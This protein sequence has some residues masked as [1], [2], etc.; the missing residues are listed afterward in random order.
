MPQVKLEANNSAE[1]SQI[2]LCTAVQQFHKHNEQVKHPVEL[3]YVTLN[4]FTLHPP[5][6][7]AI[8]DEWVSELVAVVAATVAVQQQ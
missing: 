3:H 2:S 6:D 1:H 8:V 7:C 5:V 4:A